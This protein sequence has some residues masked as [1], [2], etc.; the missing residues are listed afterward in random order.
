MHGGASSRPADPVPV[1]RNL[2]RHRKG[3]LAMEVGVP[4][5]GGEAS[6]DS[7]RGGGRNRER[8]GRRVDERD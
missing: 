3:H 1:S 8:R 6:Q 5:G 7:D 2:L 4:G